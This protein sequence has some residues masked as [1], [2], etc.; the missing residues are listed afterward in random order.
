MGVAGHQGRRRRGLLRPARRAVRRRAHAAPRPPGRT[1]TSTAGRCRRCSTRSIPARASCS[2][3]SGWTGQQ[4]TGMLWGGDQVSDWWSL[5][6]LVTATLT[7]AASG[8]LE[9]V[10]RRRRLPRADAGRA[11]PEGAAPALGGVRR[12]HAADAGARPL[13]AGGLALRR[14]DAARSTASWSCST[15]ASCPTSARPRRRRRGAACRS[16][17]RSASSTRP[18]RAAGRSA[19][20]TASA[21]RSGWR[22]CS[23][24][25]RASAASTCRGASGST[26]GPASPT[27][28]GHDAIAPAPLDRIP[29][30]VRRGSIVVTYPAEHVRRR[31]RRH[32]GGRAAAGGDALGQAGVRARQGAARRRHR[33]PLGVRALVRPARARRRRS[34]SAD[35]QGAAGLPGSVSH[36]VEQRRHRV[37]R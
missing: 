4:A 10:A 11:L 33:D 22:R 30:W 36:C 16:R 27:A 25:A 14:R 29:V 1:A 20:P 7:A 9:L 34:P 12:A 37:C 31:P 21:R 2:A 32:A 28:G 15:S 18:T 26:S 24:R 13:R 5:R 19:T 17:G 23:S 6:T 35:A 8:L 3:R